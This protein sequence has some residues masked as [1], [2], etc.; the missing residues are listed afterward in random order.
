MYYLDFRNAKTQR[1][2]EQLFKDAG[3]QHLLD[4]ASRLFR[5][6]SK[7]GDPSKQTA[8]QKRL[9]F[10]QKQATL[11]EI[12][13]QKRILLFYDNIDQIYKN[14]TIFL[15]HLGQMIKNP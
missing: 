13:D 9:N 5:T 12:T 11:H 3:I 8:D 10:K 7:N 6:A 2:I 1:D 14:I 4:K 15:W